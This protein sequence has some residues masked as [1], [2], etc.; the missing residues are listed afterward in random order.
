M[1][2][3][4]AFCSATRAQPESSIDLSDDPAIRGRRRDGPRAI[5]LIQVAPG[6]APAA[7][8]SLNIRQWAE[9]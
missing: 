7:L 5:F 6:T 3:K 4:N 8:G 9:I 2:I 1:F